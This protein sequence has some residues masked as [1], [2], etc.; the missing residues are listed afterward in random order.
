MTLVIFGFS[1]AFGNSSFYDSAWSLVPAF[2]LGYWWLVQAEGSD[3]IRM[4]LIALVVIFWSVRLTMNWILHWDGLQE[5]D[6]RYPML[7][8][9]APKL[10]FFIDFFLIHFFPTL[11]VFLGMLPIF[12]VFC[13]PTSTFHALDVVA[14]ATGLLAV[15][16]EMVADIQLHRFIAKRKPGELLDQGLWAYSRH[17]N[18]FGE[19]LFWVSLAIF[20]LAAV[21]TQWW[22][23]GLGA[24]AMLLMFLTASIPMM[25]NKVA[26]R[27]GHEALKRRVSAFFPWPPR[28]DESY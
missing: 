16:L 20:G 2:F 4:I 1:R 25:E 15:T 18:Y 5:E 10:E 26:G 19:F 7:R 24:L 22:W 13:L 9:K 8:G 14:C 21:P 3:P 17:P 27:P 12:A 6:W 28:K 11:Q 23:Q